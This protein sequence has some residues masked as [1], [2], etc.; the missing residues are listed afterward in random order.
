MNTNDLKQESE[1]GRPEE[2]ALARGFDEDVSSDDGKSGNSYERDSF[3]VDSEDESE[4]D[5]E[6]EK[7]ENPLRKRRRLKKQKNIDSEDELIIEQYERGTNA[8]KKRLKKIKRDDREEEDFIENDYLKKKAYRERQV[9]KEI[10]HQYHRKKDYSDDEEEIDR[11]ATLKNIFGPQDLAEHFE[12]DFDKEIINKDQPERLQLRFKGRKPMSNEEM[13]EETNWIIQRLVKKNGLHKDDANYLYEKVLKILEFMRI[14]YFEVMFIWKYKRHEIVSIDQQN[15]HEYELKLGDLW[16]IYQLDQEW[17]KLLSKKQA[18]QKMLN[19]LHTKIGLSERV[20]GLLQHSYDKKTINYIYEYAEYNI[21]KHFDDD[22]YY[23]LLEKKSN[24]KKFKKRNFSREIIKYGLNTV[25]DAISLTADQFAD[26]VADEKK[27]HS[28]PVI[29]EK[30]DIKANQIVRKDISY[31]STPVETLSQICEYV[32][33]EYFYHPIVKTYLRRLYNDRILISTNPLERGKGMKVYDYY[34][35]TKRI[36]LKKPN[37]ISKELWMLMVEAE[38]K[39][40]ISINFTFGEDEKQKVKDIMYRLKN[41]LLLKP[42]DIINTDTLDGMWDKVRE[43]II[44][45]LFTNHMIPV[46]EKQLR[47]ELMETAEN[48]LIDLCA[49]DL[50]Y[51]I[52]MKPYKETG[53]VKVLSCNSNDNDQACFCIINEDGYLEEFIMLSNIMRKPRDYDHSQKILYQNAIRELEKFIKK[54]M[55]HVIVVAPKNIRSQS[56]KIEL[57]TIREQIYESSMMEKPF[58]MWGNLKIAK[59]FSKSDVSIKTMGEYSELVKETVSMARYLQNPL[60]ETLNLWNDDLDKNYLLY[61]NFQPLQSNLN[62]KALKDKFETVILEIVNKKGVD[63]NDCVRHVHKASQLQ[64]ISGLGPRKANK[65]IEQIRISRRPVKK[66]AEMLGKFLEKNVYN[67]AIAFLI[68]NSRISPKTNFESDK[69][70][71]FWLDFTRIHPDFYYI[72][73][74]IAKDLFEDETHYNQ[75]ELILKIFQHDNYLESLDLVDYGKH[76]SERKNCNMQIIIDQIIEEFKAPFQDQRPKFDTKFNKEEIFYNL[77]N[78][79]VFN[80]KEESIVSLKI[81]SVDDRCIKVIT[82]NGL[83]GLVNPEDV[84]D[85]M[86]DM[87]TAKLKQMFP[88]GSFVKGKVKSIS[89]ETIKAKFSLK[90]EDLDNHKEFLRRNKILSKYNLNEGTDFIIKKELDFPVLNVEGKRKIGRFTPRP[91][92]HPH[93]RNIGLGMAQEYLADRMNGDFIF[94]PSSKGASYLNLTWKVF[95]TIIAHIPVKEGYKGPKDDISTSLTIHKTKFESLDHII[96]SFIRPCNNYIKTVVAEP[97]FL[98]QGIDQVNATLIEEK[99]QNNSRIPYYYSLEAEYSQFVVISYILKDLNIKHELIKIKADGFH[100][101]ENIFPSLTHVTKYFKDKLKTPEYQNYLKTVPKVMLGKESEQGYRKDDR[102]DNFDNRRR[103]DDSD[104]SYE[105]Y[106]SKRENR[107]N[108]SYRRRDDRY[109]RD[110]RDYRDNRRRMRSN[111]NS[112]ERRPPTHRDHYPRSTDRMQNRNQQFN[113]EFEEA[114]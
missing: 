102:R 59:I 58:V 16:F 44:S 78:E 101:H 111:S 63:I 110:N 15:P 19:F 75:N 105:R 8:P 106:K 70:E 43:E 57:N 13:V 25:A 84:K 61:L 17:D 12:T 49:D 107:H 68:I 114:N 113:I 41:Y 14:Q 21:R 31:L 76:L 71:Y 55:P 95:G 77:S 45:K 73:T 23:Q 79:N 50:K 35:P 27:I 26:N 48:F 34:Y 97:K 91:I 28:P 24:L 40:L 104:S 1:Q 87:N 72:P 9:N 85:D 62:K 3:V 89:F 86:Y 69:D 4:Y 83:M 7:R 46:F 100:F 10:E 99:K 36:F 30:P 60:A 109:E 29:E 37:S 94:R 98:K 53:D 18:V 112:Q 47:E 66:K 81:L 74:Q 42:R 93:F 22:E 108:R 67:N 56:L 92:N 33:R 38:K 6:E 65:L 90:N 64:F 103:R 2:P 82:D 39:K 52:N 32:A 51:L 54:H 11:E 88:A 80:F 96:E 20:Q 5:E